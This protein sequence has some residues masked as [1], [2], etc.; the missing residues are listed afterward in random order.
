M[1]PLTRLHRSLLPDRCQHFFC[2]KE[3]F[4]LY[5]NGI[6]YSSRRSSASSARIGYPSGLSCTPTPAIHYDGSVAAMHNQVSTGIYGRTGRGEV[7]TMSPPTAPEGSVHLIYLLVHFCPFHISSFGDHLALPMCGTSQTTKWGEARS[8]L[9]SRSKSA[10]ECYPV[11][12]PCMNQ[13][14]LMYLRMNRKSSTFL[15]T[16]SRLRES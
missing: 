5:I 4:F 10:G 2:G 15:Q 9:L 7:A 11:V 14:V 6:G 3:S 12:I 13:G 16:P 8:S 1:K